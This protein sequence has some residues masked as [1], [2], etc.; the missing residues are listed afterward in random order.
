L[1]LKIV[2]LGPTLYM[3]HF[4]NVGQ[5]PT[6]DFIWGK[7]ISRLYKQKAA[8]AVLLRHFRLYGSSILESRPT[9]DHRYNF[10][11]HPQSRGSPAKRSR[12]AKI[13]PRSVSPAE[14]CNTIVQRCAPICSAI[15]W[16]L[17]T[18]CTQHVFVTNRLSIVMASCQRN[19]VVDVLAA[20]WWWQMAS[21]II[22][23][24]SVGMSPHLEIGLH[25]TCRGRASTCQW[26]VSLGSEQTEWEVYKTIPK[27]TLLWSAA[28]SH[29]KI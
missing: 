24:V 23:R 21:P 8:I 29:V 6:K 20:L 5:S 9:T 18:D 13:T 22:S 7:F 19:I 4:R 28:Y 10:S 26:R 16:E 14:R 27:M 3:T 1:N 15:T 25:A 12:A 17:S 11:L 2:R